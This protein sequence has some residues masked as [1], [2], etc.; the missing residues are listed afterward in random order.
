LTIHLPGHTILILFI[1][2]YLN[3]LAY[4]IKISSKLPL[5]ILRN[6]YFA[7]MYLHILYGIKIYANTSSIHFRKL[8]TLNNK[9]LIRR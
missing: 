9:K 3:I 8:I 2:N 5:S 7:F 6:I 1:E 4:F